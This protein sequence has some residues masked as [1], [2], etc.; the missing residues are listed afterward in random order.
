MYMT[1]PI[2]SSVG[3]VLV[4]YVQFTCRPAFLNPF[5]LGDLGHILDA[6]SK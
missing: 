3:L 5:D 4:K 1:A 6:F 2:L